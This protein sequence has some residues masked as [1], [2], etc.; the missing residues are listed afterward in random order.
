MRV[1]H[2]DGARLASEVLRVVGGSVVHDEHE[3][4]SGDGA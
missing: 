2:H 1:A 3:I 4:H